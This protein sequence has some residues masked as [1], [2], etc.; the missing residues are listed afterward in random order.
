MS[1]F[2]R[3]NNK[4]YN[5]HEESK[6]PFK[7]FNA[8]DNLDKEEQKKLRQTKNIVK[9]QIKDEGDKISSEARYPSVTKKIN[10]KL[11]P[12]TTGSKVQKSVDARVITKKFNQNNPNRPEYVKPDEFKAAETKTKQVNPKQTRP[13]GQLVK[14]TKPSKTAISGKLTPGQIDFSKAGELAAKRKARID[15]KTGKATQAGVFDF[16]KNR[17][18]FNRMSQ[19]MSKSDFKKMITSDPKK[20]SQFK[21]IVSKAK[22]IASDPTSKAY[23]D[24]ERKINT[25]DY[26]GRIA[27]KGK[28]AYMN[29][30]QKAAEIARIKAGID[31]RDAAKGKFK[32][33]KTVL[34]RTEPGSKFRASKIKGFDVVPTSNPVGKEILKKMDTTGFVPPKPE[35]L[36]RFQKMKKVLFD[37]QRWKIPKKDWDL[38]PVRWD[39]AGNVIAQRRL[40][41]KRGPIGTLRKINAMLPTRYKVIAGLA[42]AAP[43]I[44]KTFFSPKAKPKTYTPY[45]KPLGFDTGKRN[46]DKL[47]YKKD[48]AK[49][50]PVR[51]QK[52]F[53]KLP[54]KPPAVKSKPAQY[55]SY[56]PKTKKM[57]QTTNVPKNINKNL[58]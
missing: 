33:P 4:R 24:I 29:P 5:L 56:D 25:S 7:D 49:L 3:L 31:A 46:Y 58:P 30:S 28:T 39:K 13:L 8:Y 41:F 23:K 51:F 43:T 55:G 45:K 35:K 26:A 20:A 16:A 36:T 48:L 21:N 18:G 19:G 42:L 34:K 6:D 10:K 22:K 40:S 14:K 44:K 37:P 52:E 17:G 50:D 1:L 38:K 15:T 57:V 32:K 2:E 53:P 27:R 11:S 9:K 12:T 47:R 54:K